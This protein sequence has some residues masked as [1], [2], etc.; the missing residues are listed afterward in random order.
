MIVD[1]IVALVIAPTCAA[2]DTPLERPTLGCVCPSC[3][4][5]I[6][7]LTEPFCERCGDLLSTWRVSHTDSRLCARCRRL[8]RTI[9]RGRAV[10]A[11]DGRLRDILHALKYDGRRSAAA[12]LAAL[13]AAAAPAIL[14]DA[15]FVVPVPLHFVRQYRRGFNQAEE[16]ARHLPVPMLRA[17]RRRRS[18]ATQ[19]D[20]PEAQRHRNVRDAFAV[21]IWSR[22][23]L[24]GATVVLI[25][26]VSTTGA[27]LDA[28]AKALLEAGA[29]EV[30]ALTAARAVSRRP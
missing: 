6:H 26:D 30:R 4:S 1:A 8:P 21:R 24:R 17:L 27:T 16:L 14:E 10:A 2:C 11:H 23:R 29:K 13:M 22:R 7:P 28:C 9:A 20:L 15:D 5:S 25:D 12:R 3:W 18:T 19:T